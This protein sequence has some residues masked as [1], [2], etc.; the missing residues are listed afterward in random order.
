MSGGGDLEQVTE[1]ISLGLQISPVSGGGPRLQRHSLD[2]GKAK[3]LQA[4]DL[5]GIV[6]EEAELAHAEI[7]QDLGPD[8]ELPQV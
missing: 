3:A 4:D 7:A 2:N 1:A 8:A 5:A 6:G